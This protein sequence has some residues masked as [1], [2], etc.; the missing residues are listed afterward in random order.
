MA[1][2]L[3]LFRLVLFR[4]PWNLTHARCPHRVLMFGQAIFVTPNDFQEKQQNELLRFTTSTPL[5]NNRRIKL[6]QQR[7]K[8]FRNCSRVSFEVE[9][10]TVFLRFYPRNAPPVTIVPYTKCSIHNLWKRALP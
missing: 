8:Q 9:M 7:F 1:K 2:I 4:P 5:P 10:E 6:I 3:I